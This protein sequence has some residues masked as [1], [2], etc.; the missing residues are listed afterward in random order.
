MSKRRSIVEEDLMDW[1]ITNRKR[2]GFGFY[3]D[4]KY[5]IPTLFPL[6]DPD[7]MYRALKRFEARGIA[8]QMPMSEMSKK[9]YDWSLV[10]TKD[11]DGNPYKR[12]IALWNAY[13]SGE[14]E[15]ETTDMGG[16]GR[17]TNF[18]KIGVSYPI[19]SVPEDFDWDD[20]QP[21]VSN[22]V[23]KIKAIKLTCLKQNPNHEIT[24]ISHNDKTLQCRLGQFEIGGRDNVRRGIEWVKGEL[25]YLVRAF[26][27]GTYGFELGTPNPYKF[28]LGVTDPTMTD[29][30]RTGFWQIN[31]N[32]TMDFTPPN[33]DGSPTM[34]ADSEHPEEIENVHDRLDGQKRMNANMDT[35]ILELDKMA[36]NQG[37]GFLNVTNAI[38]HNT[39]VQHRSQD[40]QQ[41]SM[42]ILERIEAKRGSDS[43][44]V[45]EKRTTLNQEF[46]RLERIN[47]EREREKWVE[48]DY[49]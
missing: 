37:V 2:T 23:K 39:E 4:A 45:C 29:I 17:K 24:L 3:K 19:F 44:P 49:V 26:L 1:L 40:I 33:H 47:A 32:V 5:H 20:I 13:H 6:H 34:H 10:S 46:L 35:L 25:C 30:A 48:N 28:K 12:S 16:T 36:V 18:R 41:K 43:R 11:A 22:T 27:Q 8:R 31:Q 21:P 15:A 38:T 42:E 14:L 9:K 7:T